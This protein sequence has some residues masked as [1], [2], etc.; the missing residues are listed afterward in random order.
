MVRHLVACVVLHFVYI[1][2]TSLDQPLRHEG[3]FEGFARSSCQ[4]AS[5]RSLHDPTADHF[6]IKGTVRPVVSAVP[7]EEVNKVLD[8]LRAGR[9]TGRK[10]VVPGLKTLEA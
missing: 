1:A 7:L 2:S 3:R 6:A 8:D 4:G 10:V 9:V 5:H